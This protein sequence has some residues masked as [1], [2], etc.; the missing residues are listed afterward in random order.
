[1]KDSPYRSEAL[2]RPGAVGIFDPFALRRIRVPVRGYARIRERLQRRALS[3]HGSR[4]A[5]RIPYR[6]RLRSPYKPKLRRHR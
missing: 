5:I 6:P 3:K 1:M 4:P 2:D